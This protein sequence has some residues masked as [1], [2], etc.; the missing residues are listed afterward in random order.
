MKKSHRKI[1][2]VIADDH[3][4]LAYGIESML[5][6]DQ[7][8]I[9]ATVNDG[10]AVIKILNS[11]PVDIIL[12]DIDMPKINGIEA[13]KII[14]EQFTDTKVLILSMHD[15]EAFIQN[16]IEAG[17]NGYILK[18]TS[19]YELDKAIKRIIDGHS[20]FSQEVSSTIALKMRLNKNTEEEVKLSKIEKQVLLLLSEGFTSDEI[21]IKMEINTHTINSYRRNMLNKFNAKNVTNLIALAFKKGLIS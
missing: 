3:E 8:H 1:N 13:T 5:N 6:K 4:I 10:K 15:E 20:F 18:S 16:A 2:V 19:L 21:S 14:N 9:V 11:K 7:Y 12:M 17:A